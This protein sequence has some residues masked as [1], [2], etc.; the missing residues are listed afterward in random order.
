[1]A[2]LTT[3]VEFD[4]LNK[5]S[6]TRVGGR[7]ADESLAALYDVCQKNS[8]D[9]NA[10][11]SIVDLSSLSEC[12]LSYQFVQRLAERKPTKADGKRRCFLVAPAA[13]VYGLCRM[14]QLLGEVTRPL[15]EVVHTLGEAFAAIA[16]QVEQFEP[17]SPRAL[18]QHLPAEPV[19]V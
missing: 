11:V 8:N 17:S 4:E 15:L 10:S 12:A 3:E 9:T 18:F 14:F 13:H 7:L 6:L 2:P 5:I 1:M 16:T 19:H